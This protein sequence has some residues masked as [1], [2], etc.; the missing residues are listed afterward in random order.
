MGQSMNCDAIGAIEGLGLI[1]GLAWPRDF[2]L[3]WSYGFPLSE[4]P[5]TQHAGFSLTR[6]ATDMALTCRLIKPGTCHNVQMSG[7]DS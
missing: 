5:L 2:L 6:H 3:R 7:L 4:P 1:L